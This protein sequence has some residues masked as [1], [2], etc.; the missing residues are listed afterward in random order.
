[1]KQHRVRGD[2]GCRHAHEACE[3]KD[4][5]VH[6]SKSIA[7]SRRRSLL[8]RAGGHA[9]GGGTGD[10]KTP[11]TKQKW[12]QRPKRL[13][14]H[15]PMYQ[16]PRN[17]PPQKTTPV[18]MHSRRVPYTFEGYSD[19]GRAARGLPTQRVYGRID[20]A[21]NPKK[22]QPHPRDTWKNGETRKQRVAQ[23]LKVPRSEINLA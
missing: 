9:H 1:M 22:Q 15:R 6:R 19:A 20:Q 21:P 2:L 14:A 12:N 16:Q 17:R 5:G 13:Y 7:P 3:F 11:P 4:E 8:T 23:C 18:K 10:M